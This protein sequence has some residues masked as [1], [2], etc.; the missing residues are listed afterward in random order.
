MDSVGGTLAV[1]FPLTRKLTGNRSTQ[2]KHRLITFKDNC[3]PSY[4]TLQFD[5]PNRAAGQVNV[6]SINSTPAPHNLT[7]STSNG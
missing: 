7:L 5:K 2:S 3:K 4:N 1:P 6:G